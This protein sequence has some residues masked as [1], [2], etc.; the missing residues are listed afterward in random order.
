MGR[1]PFLHEQKADTEGMTQCFP[2]SLYTYD[3]LTVHLN[4][5]LLEYEISEGLVFA[6]SSSER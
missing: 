6:P 1:S 4:Q 2:V 5:E 3:G